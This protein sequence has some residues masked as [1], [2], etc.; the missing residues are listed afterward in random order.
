MSHFI[1]IPDNPLTGAVSPVLS[2]FRFDSWEVL[3]SRGNLLHPRALV[4]PCANRGPDASW[5][6][7]VL[8]PT[9]TPS[10]QKC[11]LLGT[12]PLGQK[13]VLGK[14][15]SR[16]GHQA[17]ADCLWVGFKVSTAWD[18]PSWLSG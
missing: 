2:T 5:R 9:E 3:F 4:P 12:H 17:A 18:F 6:G 14:S 10:G 11:L 8:T 16:N 7:L 13:F 15:P 1:L